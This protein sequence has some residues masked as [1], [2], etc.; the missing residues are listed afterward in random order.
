MENGFEPLNKVVTDVVKFGTE[1]IFGS[2][3][4]VII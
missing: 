3:N 1:G 2:Y 4:L